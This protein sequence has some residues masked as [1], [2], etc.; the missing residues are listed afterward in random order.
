VIVCL[1]E[2]DALEDMELL[3]DLSRSGIGIIGVSNDAYALVDIDPRIKSSLSVE[4]VECPA[5]TVDEVFEILQQR[6]PYAFVPGAAPERV[7]KLAARLSDGDARIAI[8]TMRKAAL[9]AEDAERE[10]VSAEDVQK[11]FEGGTKNLRKT[12]SLKRLNDH[13]KAIYL[14]IEEQKETGTQELWEAYKKAVKEPASPRSYRN[15]CN[16]LVRLGLVDAS[17]EL[18]GREY[19][20]VG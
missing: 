20:L 6:K 8:E 9:M 15:Y 19:K 12:E 16:H 17:G 2:V 1:D 7:L 14:I 10:I 4:A 3:Y 13:E 5:Y 11:A 18:T